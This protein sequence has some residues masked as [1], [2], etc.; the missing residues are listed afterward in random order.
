MND[1]SKLK[2]NADGI[3]LHFLLYIQIQWQKSK[4]PNNTF[5]SIM[6]FFTHVMALNKDKSDP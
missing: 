4:P 2:Q 3:S 5:S 1:V 6:V